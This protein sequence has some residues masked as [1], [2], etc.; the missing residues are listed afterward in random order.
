MLCISAAYGV[1]QCPS[2]YPSACLSVTFVDSVKTSNY[3]LKIFSPLGSHTI[4]VLPH[5][6][7]RQ[8]SD[9]NPLTGALNAGG[10]SKTRDARPISDSSRAVNAASVRCYQ[11]GTAGPWQVVTL[12]AGSKRW[13]LLM[14]GDDDEMFMTRRIK[15]KDNRTAFNCTQ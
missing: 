2:V 13:S 1:M 7:S 10:L 3:I 15:A 14:A 5:Q 12:I 4:L 11:H 8:Y 6:T 9:G